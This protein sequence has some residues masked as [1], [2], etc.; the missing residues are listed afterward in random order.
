MVFDQQGVHIRKISQNSSRILT[1]NAGLIESL[2][3]QTEIKKTRKPLVL[4]HPTCPS[5]GVVLSGENAT[6]TWPG[7]TTGLQR[8]SWFYVP[9]GCTATLVGRDGYLSVLLI[10]PVNVDP[11]MREAALQGEP[12]AALIETL[13]V[14]RKEGRI[15]FNAAGD[16]CPIDRPFFMASFCIYDQAYGSMPQHVHTDQEE[17]MLVIRA[18]GSQPAFCFSKHSVELQNETLIHVF[19]GDYHGFTPPDDGK[20]AIVALY[21]VPASNAGVKIE[22]MGSEDIALWNAVA[23]GR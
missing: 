15:T 19:P 11:G 8:W 6:L 23:G 18:T 9:A 17:C 1:G 2:K 4:G 16:G 3:F 20:I 5:L 22:A 14:I 12:I 7:H 10:R 13:K 21:Q